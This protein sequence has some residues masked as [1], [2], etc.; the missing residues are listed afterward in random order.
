ML[1]SAHFRP[2][3]AS[4]CCSGTAN[5]SS[6]RTVPP[7]IRTWISRPW[8]SPTCSA[9]RPAHSLA[10]VSKCGG[11]PPS[12]PRRTLSGSTSTRSRT[13]DYSRGV[14]S[15][16]PVDNDE[17]L[18]LPYERVVGLLG[19]AAEHVCDYAARRGS[20]RLLKWTRENNLDWSVMTCTTQP[21]RG[22]CPLSSTCTRTGALGTGHVLLRSHEWAL[23]RSQVLARERVPLGLGARATTPPI[24]NTGTVCSTRWI[25]SATSGR[26]TP[27]NTRSTSDEMSPLDRRLACITNTTSNQP[28]SR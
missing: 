5:A 20:V 28:V 17:A 13:W 19:E 24:T 15:H 23:A 1:A 9:S 12:L 2:R 3:T 8:S 26:N 16:T 22:T 11:T 10:V 14:S 25:T 6:M 4:T 7:S 21:K 18:S 27:R